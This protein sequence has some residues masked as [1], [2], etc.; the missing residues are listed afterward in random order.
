MLKKFLPAV[1]L[2]IALGTPILSVGLHAP[3]YLTTQEKSPLAR[4]VKI[5]LWDVNSNTSGL[6]LVPV[7]RRVAGAAVLRLTLESLFAGAT[8]EEEAKG[9][10]SSTFGMKFEGVTLTNGI[11]RV[12]FSQ[13][14]NQTNYGSQG[15][16]ILAEA[17]EKTARQFPAVK[18]VEICAVGETLIDSQLE[19]PFPR[20]AK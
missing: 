5:F 10:N 9:L 2:V 15:P 19:K 18:K 13:P 4:E 11:A 16:M 8:T 14:L 12:K 3:S 17:I 1:L 7:K 6:G 20:C